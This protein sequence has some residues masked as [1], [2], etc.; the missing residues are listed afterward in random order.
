PFGGRV[1]QYQVV[2]DPFA[3]GK[4]GL[5]IGRIAA[6]INANNKNAGGAL[7]DNRQQSLV[8]RGV[9]L[10]RSS[11]DIEN[12]VVAASRGVP[13]FVRDGGRVGMGSAPQTGLFGI[14]DRSGGVEGIVLMR[15]GENPSEVLDGVS[16]AIDELNRTRLPAGVRIV[17]FYDRRDL[18]GNTLRTVS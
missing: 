2:V 14:N 16:A 1:K 12:I 17:P 9:G 11:S 7:I 4:Y 5:T 8:I 15:R 18:V 13:V 10:I 6:A 3:M